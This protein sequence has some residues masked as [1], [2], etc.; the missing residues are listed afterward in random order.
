MSPNFLGQQCPCIISQEVGDTLSNT[1]A[2]SITDGI[3]EK[4]VYIGVNVA[5]AG[6]TSAD[7]TRWKSG[8]WGIGAAFT[9][10][11]NTS[12][13]TTN[14]M[15]VTY[16]TRIILN[17]AENVDNA[18]DIIKRLNWF[19]PYHFEYDSLKQCTDTLGQSFHWLICDT[20]KSVVVE[21]LDNKPVITTSKNIQSLDEGSVMTNYTNCLKDR[22]ALIQHGGS[23]YE[24]T[25][26]VHTYYYSHGGNI[27]SMRELMH[28]LHYSNFYHRYYNEHDNKADYDFRTEFAIPGIIPADSIIRSRIM[29][30]RICKIFVDSLDAICKK[31]PPCKKASYI[32]EKFPN[33]YWYSTHTCIYDLPSKSFKVLIHEG[34]DE[35]DYDKKDLNKLYYDASLYDPGNVK[36]VKNQ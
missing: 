2:L 11:D 6:E 36:R 4:G 21:F 13:S 10:P 28:L 12:D 27:A 22:Y 7:S 15:C 34:M 33:E 23:G 18:V 1:L 25:G 31:W 29:S 35:L 16:L 19:E 9:N 14:A 32:R 17:Y 5:P 3:N 26:A 24:R 8:H 30:E 20:N